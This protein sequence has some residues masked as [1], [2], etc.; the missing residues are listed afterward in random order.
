M[1]P[2]PTSSV[3]ADCPMIEMCI[4]AVNTGAGG[5]GSADK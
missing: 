1:S 3:E 2:T 5:G 4:N